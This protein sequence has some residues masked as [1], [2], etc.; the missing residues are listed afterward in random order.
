MVASKS[1][2]L[3]LDV[4]ISEWPP[5][6]M[7]TQNDEWEGIAVDT[8]HLISICSDIQ[9][10]FTNTVNT[11]RM[12]REWGKSV[13]AEPAIAE[14][15]RNSQADSS[16]YTTSIFST[17]DIILAQKKMKKIKDYKGL[18]GYTVGVINGFVYPGFND[19]IDNGEIKVSVSVS[20]AL[21][22]KLVR[23]RV[24][25]VF[26]NKEEALYYFNHKTKRNDSIKD[27]KIIY[28]F[29]EVPLKIRL[30][31]SRAQLV[32][33]FDSVIKRLKEQGHLQKIQNYY[34][35]HHRDNRLKP[36]FDVCPL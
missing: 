3:P 27:Y 34:L 26:A 14:V 30:H 10:K 35:M 16:V 32:P 28:W 7:K 1:T 23:G 15:W 19:A 4:S 6:S 5:W 25:A 17:T 22:P 8:M 33:I 12:L 2:H 11:K 13:F 24:D 29:E 21:L 18:Q 20:K 36:R 31:T 9:F